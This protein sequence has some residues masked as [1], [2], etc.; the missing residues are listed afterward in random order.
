VSIVIQPLW[1]PVQLTNAAVAYY[2]AGAPTQINKLTVANPNAAAF[3]CSI[4][5]VP[6]G[7]APGAGNAIA[8]A[9]IIQPL[10]TWD[11][12]GL[13]GHVLNTGD[14]IQALANTGGKLNFFGSGTVDS[15]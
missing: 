4:F 10:E 7:G 6:S 13:V 2:T 5:W 11:V 14:M 8:T 3:N 9:R 15:G 1:E 12:W